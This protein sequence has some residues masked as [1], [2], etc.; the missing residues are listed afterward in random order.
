[1]HKAHFSRNGNLRV[2][3]V[4][5]LAIYGIDSI[6]Y[7]HGHIQKHRMMKQNTIEYIVFPS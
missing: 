1:M 3:Y 2:D 4:V 7:A 5:E 6:T